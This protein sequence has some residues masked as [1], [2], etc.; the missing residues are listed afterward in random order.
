LLSKRTEILK[1][2]KAQQN[3]FLLCF[4]VLLL[5]I[6]SSG[7]IRFIKTMHSGDN[8][9]IYSYKR[10]M[11]EQNGYYYIPIANQS[12]HGAEE[13]R[14]YILKLDY[15]GNIVSR[16]FNEWEDDRWSAI[17]E[18]SHNTMWRLTINIDSVQHNQYFRFHLLDSNLNEI[19][20]T[21]VP[22]CFPSKCIIGN[23]E[24]TYLKLKDGGGIF[25]LDV[26]AFGWS[27]F[28]NQEV[29]GYNFV[30]ISKEGK[31]IGNTSSNSFR[32]FY[33]EYE[34]NEI[35][36]LND[37]SILVIGTLNGCKENCAVA[38]MFNLKGVE[39]TSKPIPK[40]TSAYKKHGNRFYAIKKYLDGTKSFICFNQNFD[41]LYEKLI[42]SDI[43]YLQF[44]DNGDNNDFRIRISRCELDSNGNS[45]NDCYE[46]L[47]DTTFARQNIKWFLP[48]NYEELPDEALYYKS[49]FYPTQ[50]G[51][52]F[53][54][55]NKQLPP[56]GEE[57][58]FVKADT[59][60]K[61]YGNI[62]TVKD[63]N[64]IYPNPNDQNRLFLEKDN[65]ETLSIYDLT[66]REL[67]YYENPLY[68]LMDG[69]DIED[70]RRGNY[71][72]R[73]KLPD[74]TVYNKFIRY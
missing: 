59:V 62:Y 71:F 60:Y 74:K 49:M 27:P 3:Y 1:I 16:K 68:N 36:Q 15:K 13:N 4:A 69:I 9:W 21:K 20:S 72:L 53:Y 29:Y 44:M 17:F 33:S 57:L 37:T 12:K 35:W 73:I 5:A 32:N 39:I 56:D 42:P 23:E 24:R 10:N 28:N 63:N 38:K 70:L 54:I 8:N 6:N 14:C 43:N 26:S 7:Q 55:Y 66:G 52:A 18:A 11:V 61:R 46:S 47:M 2:I 58:V 41:F 40:N 67:L 64:L 25:I 45:S 50:D 51:G 65:W 19:V 30:H 34:G 48:D 31:L 22:R